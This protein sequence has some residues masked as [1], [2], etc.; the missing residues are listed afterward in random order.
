MAPN[1]LNE[2]LDSEERKDFKEYIQMLV[3]DDQQFFLRNDIIYFFRQ[4]CDEK[5]KDPDYREKS[6]LFNFL[7]KVQELFVQG[8]LITLLHR[9]DIAR[10]RYYRLRVDAEHMEP[11]DVREYLDSKD[12]YVLQRS[13]NGSHLHLD[14]LPFYDTLPSIRDTR[15][16]GHGIR[17]LNRYM[18]SS[19]FS[20]PEKWNRKLFDFIKMH[21]YNGRQLLVNGHQIGNFRSFIDTLEHSIQWLKRRNPE[22]PYSDVAAKLQEKGIE[23]GWGNTVGRILETMQLLI[24]L[25]NEPT[26]QEFEAFISRVPMPLISKIAI[27]SPHGWFGQTNVLGRPDTGGQVIYILD[28]VRALEHHLKEEIRLTGLDDVDPKIIV[29]TRLIPDADGTTCG[30]KREKIFQTDNGWILRI[31]FRDKEQNVIRQW[32][33]RFKVWPYLE[34]FAED[35][36]R[37]LSSEFGGRPD[38]V[39]GNYSDGNMVATLLSDHFDVIQ[40]T[41]AHALEKT[42]YLFSDMYWFDKEEDYHFSLQFTADMLSM[43]KSD[44]II[45]STHQ[46]ITGTEDTMGQYESYQQFTMPGLF[47]VVSGINLL[48][49]KF[50]VIPP[51]V[52]ESLYFPYFER[53]RRTESQQRHWEGRLFTEP[54]EDIFGELDHPDKPPIFTMARFDKIKNI[55]G[56]I[57]AFGMSEKLQE[58]F[59]LVFAAGTIHIEESHDPEEQEEIRKAYNLIEQYGL[60]GKIRWLPSISKLETGEVYRIIADRRGIFVQPA[61][62]EAFGLTILEAMA[63]GLPT[64]GPKFGGPLEIIEYGISGLLLNT[65]KPELI[66]AS[67]EEYAEDCRKDSGYWKSL[68]ENGIRRVQEHFN[69]RLYSRRLINLTKLYG[70]WRYSV[71]AKE[72]TTLD[73]YCD[74]IHHFLFRQ[75]AEAMIRTGS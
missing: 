23:V 40:C 14:F 64:F 15:T 48:A 10:Y 38:L 36:A 70:F 49:P 68:S 47:Q 67:L 69:W 12:R 52:E 45:T 59:N 20:N 41:I 35:A 11:I 62:F 7:K 61:L 51:G 19:I 31:P 72:K 44:F 37:E 55:T 54:L 25:I 66:A 8:D 17:F 46:E 9:Y 39:I 34:D 30:E 6:S 24:D 56:L 71:S 42:K 28:Q 57:E 2:L 29:I 74:T 73:R 18:C 27:I 26:D 32:I 3:A 60:T 4:Y 65:S 16:V 63:S 5:D 13:T 43:N 58:E 33:S 22:S 21:R 1:A 75:R 53:D 50:N